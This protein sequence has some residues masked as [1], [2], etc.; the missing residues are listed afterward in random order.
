M[1]D[2]KTILHSMEL[3]PDVLERIIIDYITRKEITFQPFNNGKEMRISEDGRTLC[4]KNKNSYEAAISSTP[5]SQ[6]RLR[7]KVEMLSDDDFY[8]FIGIAVPGCHEDSCFKNDISN[9]DSKFISFFNENGR[10]TI[11]F[12]NFP[13]KT[14]DYFYPSRT[15][16]M[17]VDLIQSTL[18]LCVEESDQVFQV[19][20]NHKL[21]KQITGKVP[22][23]T[24]IP[25][26]EQ[27]FPFV[28]ICPCLE[29]DCTLVVTS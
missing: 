25:N 19:D 12:N 18:F 22:I 15:I 20:D 14:I 10:N 13:K 23:A 29:N 8:C 26:L 4:V 9:L 27:C 11:R 16:V 24:N 21:T 5:F 28:T 3:F 1:C 7:W 17:E 6:C 2:E